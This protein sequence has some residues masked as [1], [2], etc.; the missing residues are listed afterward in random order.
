METSEDE[1]IIENNYYDDE[2]DSK[3]TLEQK[4]QENEKAI[5]NNLNKKIQN[6]S[7]NNNITNL[8]QIK[9][10]NTATLS[11]KPSAKNKQIIS[12]SVILPKNTQVQKKYTKINNNINKSNNPFRNPE[13]KPRFKTPIEVYQEVK[14]DIDIK[15][16]NNVILNK[17]EGNSDNNHLKANVNKIKGN[18]IENIM[19]KNNKNKMTQIGNNIIKKIDKIH[20]EFVN[21]TFLKTNNNN[22]KTS[23]TKKSENK[24]A[25][26]RNNDFNAEKDNHI[27][28]YNTII[29]GGEKTNKINK[30]IKEDEN[31]VNKEK[32]NYEENNLE[33]CF[34]NNEINNNTQKL[35][36]KYGNFEQ[37]NNDQNE[38]EQNK[39]LNKPYQ[40]KTK[41]P[42]RTYVKK[43][44]NLNLKK[45]EDIENILGN[46]NQI[47]NNSKKKVVSDLNKI[48][49][50]NLKIDKD[51]KIENKKE[52]NNFNKKIKDKKEKLK[53]LIY[54]KLII[55]K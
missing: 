26:I 33:N 39:I 6:N 47:I 17:K 45:D 30:L 54:K 36:I 51:I 31:I 53:I 15:N 3:I 28:K 18:K 19:V 1:E 52:E 10:G 34:N 25:I 8:N 44:I 29:Y 40:K 42:R 16:N 21:N 24:Q 46:I 2:F 32:V 4:T 37:I 49:D 27:S 50:S 55:L 9:K 43:Q 13:S 12:V 5:K 41:T 14:A 20:E 23:K 38:N 7:N 11:S 48:N 35:K 22:I